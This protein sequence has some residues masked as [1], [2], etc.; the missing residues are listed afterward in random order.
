MNDDDN[1]GML[2]TP[3]RYLAD[4]NFTYEAYNHAI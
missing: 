2:T 1:Y 4:Q 3:A